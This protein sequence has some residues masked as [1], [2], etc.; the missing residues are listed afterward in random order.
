[1]TY[2]RSILRYKNV[3]KNYENAWIGDNYNNTNFKFKQLYFKIDKKIIHNK[4]KIDDTNNEIDKNIKNKKENTA[5]Y[6]YLKKIF[7]VTFLFYGTY[8]SINLVKNIKNY[9]E[10]DQQLNSIIHVKINSAKIKF[11][12]F[13]CQLNDNMFKYIKQ[14]ANLNIILN[15]ISEFIFYLLYYIYLFIQVIKNFTNFWNSTLRINKLL[16]INEAK[17]DT[18][19]KEKSEKEY[20]KNE[21]DGNVNCDEKNEDLYKDNIYSDIEDII[22]AFNKLK[23]FEIHENYNNLKIDKSDKINLRDVECLKDTNNFYFNTKIK[24]DEKEYYIINLHE[25]NKNVDN[26][27]ENTKET[28]TASPIMET[29]LSMQTVSPKKSIIKLK[30][31]AQ[32]N[33]IENMKKEEYME[34][35]NEIV[36]GRSNVKD[37]K[38][39]FHVIIK[40]DEQIVAKEDAQLAKNM[41]NENKRHKKDEKKIYIDKIEKT[42]IMPKNI[43]DKSIVISEKKTKIVELEKEN[44][45]YNVGKIDG[46]INNKKGDIINNDQYIKNILEKELTNFKTHINSLSK[47]DLQNKIVDM[48]VNELVTERYK[49]ILLEEEK[50]VLKKILTIKYNDIFLKKKK[51]VEKALKKSMLKILKEEEKLLKENYEKKKE[52]FENNIIDQT[53]N[54]IDIE[55]NKM[56]NELKEIEEN[57]LKKIN[58]YAYDINIIK[59]NIEKDKIRQMKLQYINDIQ[60]KLVYLQ[61]CIIHDLSIEVILKD[62]KEHLKKDT[63]LEKTLKALPDNFFTCTYKLN[64]N[65]R[66]QIK[67]KFYYLYKL[68]VKEAFYEHSNN[69]LYK[70][71]SNLFSYFYIN[72]ETTS[73]IIL[74]RALK[75]NLVLKENL[76]NLSYALNSIKKNKFIDSLQYIEGLTGG[77]KQTFESFNE[78]I[79]NVTLFKFYLRMA[80]SR[81]SLLSKLMRTYSEEN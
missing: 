35:K 57:Y 74:A 59:E 27:G 4:K 31:N 20:I 39:D 17:I 65:N 22:H 16:G 48:Y 42:N 66:E 8:E 5:F 29:N 19:K 1:M 33:E 9:I 40:S 23:N 51:K 55:K 53:K 78:D 81:L 56:K 15:D 73:N 52:S 38:D 49:D 30:E 75:N 32:L 6:A 62:L 67:N 21:Q 2:L 47:K 69:Y 64:N 41:N 70:V 11:E 7:F 54:E 76:L 14:N 12:R 43:L 63:F 37:S 80:V 58:T 24:E 10:E 77:C 46:T 45:T 26:Y 3:L 61:N 44:K 71:L 50:E 36:N 68:S 28:K 25:Q 79:K 13:T 72:Y 18:I 34:E 60:H